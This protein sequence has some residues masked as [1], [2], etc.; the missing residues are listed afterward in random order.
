MH[1]KAK[2]LHPGLEPL[3]PSPKMHESAWDFQYLQPRYEVLKE[4]MFRARIVYR[5][6]Y[7]RAEVAGEHESCR[8]SL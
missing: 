7:S 8:K 1:V 3:P 6:R 2:L 5:E 4:Y